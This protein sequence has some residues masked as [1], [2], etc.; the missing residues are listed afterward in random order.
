MAHRG[1]LQVGAVDAVA[2][3]MHHDLP[4]APGLELYVDLACSGVKCIVDQ[5]AHNRK[6][7]LDYLAGGDTGGDT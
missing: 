4:E 6:R 7:A 2:V 3:V 5:F 1:A